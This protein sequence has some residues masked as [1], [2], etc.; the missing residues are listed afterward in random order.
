VSGLL[1][2]A[3]VGFFGGWNWL[4]LVV[5]CCGLLFLVVWC[6]LAFFVIEV[7]CVDV[8]FFFFFRG[9]FLGSEAGGFGGHMDRGASGSV[10][11]FCQ[12]FCVCAYFLKFTRWLLANVFFG[13][14]QKFVRKS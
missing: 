5:F 4:F 9:R 2:V 8:C 3:V 11:F 10:S 1:W 7:G 14:S 13:V 6:C 12:R